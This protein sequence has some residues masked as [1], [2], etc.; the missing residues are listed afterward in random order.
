MGSVKAKKHSSSIDPKN[1][2][3]PLGPE[4]AKTKLKSNKKEKITKADLIVND[5]SNKEISQEVL[6]ASGAEQQLS[7]FLDQFQSANRVQ[8]SSIELESIKGTFDCG[9]FGF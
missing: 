8:L 7:F 6:P 5:E 2:Q 1:K 4:R 9:L 3:K